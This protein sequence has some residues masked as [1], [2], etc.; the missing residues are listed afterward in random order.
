M[1]PISP[2]SNTLSPLFGTLGATTPTL[3]TLAA[4][5]LANAPASAVVT[6][7][8]GSLDALAQSLKDAGHAAYDRAE[9]VVDGV[10][11]TAQD[12]CNDVC[13]LANSAGSE[14]T[15]AYEGLTDTVGEALHSVGDTVDTAAGY[16]GAAALLG[17]NL[18]DAMA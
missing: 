12:L 16:V 18:I 17:Y 1:S 2:Y 7:S 11:G 14:I 10:V 15:H 6:L 8:Q 4:A 9:Q 13:D 3:P 5:T